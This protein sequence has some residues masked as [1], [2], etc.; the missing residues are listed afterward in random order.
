MSLE[1]DVKKY[2][3]GTISFLAIADSLTE[4]QLDSSLD[5]EWTLRQI[6]H[7]V[8]DSEAQSYTR[9][10]RLIAEPGTLI[11]GYDDAWERIKHLD[12]LSLL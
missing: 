1:E 7:P 9:L 6:I 12:I 11:Q 2:K 8:A 10:R 5:G 4:Q 3:E